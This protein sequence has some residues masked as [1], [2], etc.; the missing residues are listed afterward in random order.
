VPELSILD[1]MPFGRYKGELIGTVIEDEPRY[2]YWAI[3][4]TDLW[5]DEQAMK[6]LAENI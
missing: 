3:N 5:L 6:Y 4:N 2:I 1:F